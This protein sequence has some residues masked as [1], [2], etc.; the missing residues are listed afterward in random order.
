[1]TDARLFFLFRTSFQDTRPEINESID[2]PKVS[3]KGEKRILK[4][5]ETSEDNP[6]V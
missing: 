5:H 6:L 1:M 4:T 3:P 2:P